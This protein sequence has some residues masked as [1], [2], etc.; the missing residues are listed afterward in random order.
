MGA[1]DLKEFLMTNHRRITGFVAIALLAVA[2][3]AIS[4][5]PHPADGAG[6]SKASTVDAS[7]P[8]AANFDERWSAIAALTPREP[9]GPQ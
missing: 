7:E 2:T 6:Y 9:S 1:W 5:R 3:T 4:K 8:A